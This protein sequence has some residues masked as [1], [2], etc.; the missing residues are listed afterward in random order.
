MSST[1]QKHRDFVGEPMGDKPVTSLSGI[2]DILGTKLEQQDFDTDESGANK[3]Q[4][5]SCAQCL[6][7][8]CSAFL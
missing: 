6:Q 3:R 2:G 4:T 1:S 7:E 8:W 5:G